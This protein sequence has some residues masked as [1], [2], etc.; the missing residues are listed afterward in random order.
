M[1]LLNEVIEIEAEGMGCP[2][3]REML[4]TAIYEG[5]WWLPPSWAEPVLSSRG[6]KSS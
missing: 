3:A 5:V 6:R 4:L 1:L 2:E